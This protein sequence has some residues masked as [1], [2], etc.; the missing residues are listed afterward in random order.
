MIFSLLSAYGAFWLFVILMVGTPGPAN[1]LV[2]SAG[3]QYG[4]RAMLP[5]QA[6]L[7]SGKILLNIGVS[8]GLATFLAH[9]QN[10]HFF[11]ALISASYMGYLAL[12]GWNTVPDQDDDRPIMGF[13][14]GL[15]V[16][17]L[18]PKAW[19]MTSL[20]YSQFAVNFE[21]VFVQYALVPLSFAVAQII[22]HSLWCLAGAILGKRLHHSQKLNRSLILLTLAVVI[23]ALL[24]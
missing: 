9:Y 10:A 18:N 16:H 2:M 14:A 5:F 19:V 13:R 7:V 8:F 1:M 22:F 24:Q 3:A 6:G 4:F 12:R 23:W 20:A 21:G 15:F 11:L 17:P